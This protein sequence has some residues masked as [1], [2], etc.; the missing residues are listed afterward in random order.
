MNEQELL[1]GRAFG[2]PDIVKNTKVR[3][4]VIVAELVHAQDLTEKPMSV[5]RDAWA[6]AKH[7]HDRALAALEAG[8]FDRTFAMLDDHDRAIEHLDP[9]TPPIMDHTVT[10]AIAH[11]LIEN[12]TRF[13]AAHPIGTI[14]TAYDP[15]S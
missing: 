1:L 15:E 2:V 13:V 4:E 12:L 14:V 7:V 9:Y 11:T 8:L 3:E 5:Q 6:A 10:V